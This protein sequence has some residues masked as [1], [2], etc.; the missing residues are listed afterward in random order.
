MLNVYIYTEGNTEGVIKN[1][2]FIDIGN[3]G[4]QPQNNDKHNNTENN[5]TQN[6]K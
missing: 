3:N 1:G 2:Q 4:H 6:I 5:M